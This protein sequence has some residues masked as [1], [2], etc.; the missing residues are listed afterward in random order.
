MK[1]IVDHG[2]ESLVVLHLKEET[3]PAPEMGDKNTDSRR[4]VMWNLA[5]TAKFLNLD[6]L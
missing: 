4:T 2:Q 5:S 6:L 1:H 3:D